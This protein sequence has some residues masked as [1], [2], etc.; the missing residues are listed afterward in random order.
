MS[1]LL[2]AEQF[3]A[4]FPKHKD[5]ETWAAT[6]DYVL[7]EFG[8]VEPQQIAMFLAQCGHESAEFTVFQENLNYSADGLMKT[9]PK[10]FRD[11]DPARYARQPQRIANRVYANRMENG[12]EASGDGWKY[13]GR[14]VIQL[15]GRRNYRLCSKYL[16]DDENV[17]LNDPDILL[18]KR[19]GLLAALWFWE[20]HNLDDIDD[21][22]KSTRIINGGQHGIKDRTR[23]YNLSLSVLQHS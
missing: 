23:L 13:R 4:I 1:T 20:V 19:D 8:L 7:F 6:L 22:V 3:A 15:T 12:N 17:L 10:Y 21:I 16:Y 14:G 2:T 9:F 5:P 18:E 11:V